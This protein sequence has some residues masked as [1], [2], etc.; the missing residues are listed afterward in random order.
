MEIPSEVRHLYLA[1][2]WRPAR[3]LSVDDRVPEYHP[4][5][6]VLQEMGGLHVGQAGYAIECA[7]SELIFQCCVVVR[8]AFAGG[9]NLQVASDAQ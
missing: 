4:A 9:A 2:G 6:D 3:R 5:H 8:C 1:A 7:S